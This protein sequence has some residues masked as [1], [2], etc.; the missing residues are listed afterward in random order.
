V[1]AG[2]LRRLHVMNDV[3]RA[4]AERRFRLRM[5]GATAGI[6][7][8]ISAVVLSFAESVRIKARSPFAAPSDTWHLITSTE[9]PDGLVPDVPLALL[10]CSLTLFVATTLSRLDTSSGEQSVLAQLAGDLTSAL[11]LLAAV[12]SC[13]L[14]ATGWASSGAAGV[15]TCFL[16]ALVQCAVA[17]LGRPPGILEHEMT[18][19]LARARRRRLRRW[20]KDLRRSPSRRAVPRTWHYGIGAVISSPAATAL[21]A[22]RPT[23]ASALVVMVIVGMTCGWT[24]YVFR[25]FPKAAA[26]KVIGDRWGHATTVYYAPLPMMTTCLAVT[27]GLL[28]HA[29]SALALGVLLVCT[30]LLWIGPLAAWLILRWQGFVDGDLIRAGDMLRP[31]LERAVRDAK[32]RVQRA[33]TT[34]NS[35]D[36]KA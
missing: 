33:T 30:Q 21:L 36:H 15:A 29:S 5:M 4:L 32:R 10:G 12:L 26:R 11:T 19:H 27:A 8:A 16:C 35:T 18:L 14:G 31:D 23:R 13:T 1:T 22:Q 9:L 6:A 7:V 28:P 34:P 24:S 3:K 2:D 17:A 20:L 25:S